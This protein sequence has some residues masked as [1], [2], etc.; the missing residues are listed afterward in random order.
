LIDESIIGPDAIGDNYSGSDSQVS[1]GFVL[2][3]D[4]DE[5]TLGLMRDLLEINGYTVAAASG[6]AEGIDLFRSLHPHVVITDIRMPHVDGLEVLRTLRRADDTV[7][8]ILVTGHGDLEHA[9]K[10]LRTGAYDFLQKPINADILLSTVRQG[11][12]HCRLKR[13]AKDYTQ[14]L[15][16]QVEERTRELA[17]TNDFLKGILESSTGVS[18]VLTDFE[19]RVLF[20]NKGAERIYGYTSDEMV[21][22]LITRIYTEE[23]R[24]RKE[25]GAAFT[26]KDKDS[27]TVQKKMVQVAKDGRR[28]TISLTLSPMLD[29]SGA[30][31]GRLGL[32]LDVTEEARLH[33]ELLESYRRIQRI[34]HSS[35]F[36]LAKLAES[37]DGETAHHLVRLQEY[38][39]V[40]C[41][42]LKT[43][44]PY[45]ESLTFRFIDDLVQSSILH[46]IGKVAL[47]DEILFHEG[48][49]GAEEFKRMKKHAEFGGKALEEAAEETGEESFLS[50]GRDIAYFHHERWDGKGYPYGL[51]GEDIPKSARIVA[52]ADVYDAL[53]SERRYKRAFSHEEA[54]A[55]ILAER[56]GQF[57]PVV[58][59]AFLEVED[60][61]CRIRERIGANGA[62][63]EP[64]RGREASR[65]A[66]RLA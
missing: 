44:A 30:A 56:G 52:L 17:E 24:T 26:P 50:M 40:L 43:K 66:A 11:M 12:E 20:W 65:S 15:E 3:V 27:V 61:F 28:L 60:E 42:N 8:V 59:D 7:A 55:V 63:C 5:A 36:A 21:G 33:E 34:Q 45:R 57:D 9:I 48:K 31:R 4:D 58:V 46:D 6:G 23:N 41:R 32:G 35:I 51:K 13:F 29:A 37:R 54:K 22:S 49:F 39:R 19:G 14:V 53:T 62:E 18:I 64:M 25:M 16:A 1:N 47:Q 2:V 38:C 10:A